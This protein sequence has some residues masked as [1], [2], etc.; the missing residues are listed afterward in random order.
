MKKKIMMTMK[1]V[2]NKDRSDFFFRVCVCF[3]FFVIFS[4]ILCFD[5]F[6]IIVMNIN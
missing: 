5:F 2:L 3:V 6:C 1:M 4:I